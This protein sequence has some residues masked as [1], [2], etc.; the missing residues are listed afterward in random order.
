MNNQGAF[1]GGKMESKTDIIG[2]DPDNIFDCT[3]LSHYLTTSMASIVLGMKTDGK[4][5]VS[6]RPFFYI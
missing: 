2:I 6:G 4:F 5:S 3:I 1:F